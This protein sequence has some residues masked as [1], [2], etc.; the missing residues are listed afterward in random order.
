MSVTG[1]RLKKL[2]LSRHMSQADVAKLIGVERVTYLQYEKG[3]NKPVRKLK[4]LANLFNVSIDYLLGNSDTFPV[5][6]NYDLGINVVKS[7]PLDEKQTE[8]ING[9]DELNDDGRLLLFGMLNS[10]RQSHARVATN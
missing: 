2:R 8:L 7:R 6:E 10:L 3:T 4:E 5:T 9:Y 1:E